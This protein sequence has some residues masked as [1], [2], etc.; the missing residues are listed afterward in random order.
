[1]APGLWVPFYNRIEPHA[2]GN[3]LFLLVAGVRH[4]PHI[5]L[6]ILPVY[7]WHQ[8][9]K[10]DRPPMSVTIVVFLVL[11]VMVGLLGLF[12][13]ALAGRRPVATA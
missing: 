11:F 9:R 4:L 10:T 8:G 2:A 13:I 12:G 6:C 3:S 7:F 5:A 1:M